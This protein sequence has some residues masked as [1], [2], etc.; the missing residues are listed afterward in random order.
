MIDVFNDIRYSLRQLARSPGF[1]LV[2]VLTLA[3]G[4]GASTM[5]FSWIKGLVFEPLRA[6]P[7]QDRL[8]VISGVAQDGGQRSFSVPTLQDLQKGGLPLSLV[9]YDMQQVSLMA[10]DQPEQVWSSIVSGDFFDVLG[11]HAAVGRTFLPEEDK[12]PGGHPVVVLGWPFWQKRFQ[13]DPKVVG[14]QISIN[15]HSF[16]V[17]GVAPPEFAGAMPAMRA[18]LWMPLAME[19]QVV[20]GGNRLD[21]RGNFW[22]DVVARLHPGATREQAQAALDTVAARLARTYPDSNEGLRFEA[23]PYWSAP[24]GPSPFLKPVLL[25]LGAM[26]LLVLLLACAN[27]ANLMF[28]RALGRRKEISVRS[29]LGAA[30]GRLIRQLFTEGLVLALAAGVVG[31]VLARSGVGL[32]LAMVPPTNAP[33]APTFPLDAKILLFA[34]ALTLVTGVLFSL[35]PA[36]QGTQTHLASALR[37]AG[38]AVAGGRKGRIRNILVVAQITLSCLLLIIAGLFFRSL[39]RAAAVDPGFKARNALLA[40]IDLFPN[41]YDRPRGITFYRELLHRAA[42]IPGVE[43][44]TLGDVIPLEIRGNRELILTV[45]GYQPAPKE[46]VVVPFYSVGPDYFRTLQIPLVAGRDFTF[47]DDENAPPVMVINESMARRYWPGRQALGGQVQI[48]D[49]MFTVV[50][51]AKDGK[52]KSLGESPQPYFFLPMTLAFRAATVVHMRTAGDP[53]ALL[54]ALRHEIAAIDPQVA[55]GRVTTLREH[56]RIASFSQR[57]AASFLGAFGLLALAFATLGQYSVIRFAVSQRKRELGVRVALGATPRDL[58]RLVI[59]QGMVLALLGIAFGLAGA[60]TL[61]RLLTSQL[62]GV[63]TTDPSVFLSVPVLLVVIS[64]LAC[65]LPARSAAAVDPIQALRTE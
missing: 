48:I 52:Y 28:V 19:E 46:E 65:W 31:F 14:R 60:L 17:I 36:V 42:A 1:T 40:S 62:L 6:V 37:D 25:L 18:E 34:I 20:P 4:L 11:V 44:V 57:L 56:L 3:V 10:G 27:V 64:A 59:G 43:A 22:L 21:Q 58:A 23:S 51:I 63:S 54:P 33:V 5:A 13:G 61:T 29:A 53:S 38:G 50:G 32:L 7:A 12:E 26:A 2:A 47:Q 41:G 9:G 16:T 30:R 39:D 55:I 8:L 24:A 15:N 45:K 35:A 49:K